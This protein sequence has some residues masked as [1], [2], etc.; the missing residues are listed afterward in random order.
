[1][2]PTSPTTTPSH[3]AGGA[4]TSRRLE[5]DDLGRF[6]DAA[7]A[8]STAHEQICA[9]R[10]PFVAATGEL[11]QDLGDPRLAAQHEG[12]VEQM[13]RTMDAL[14]TCFEQF[15]HLLTEVGRAYQRTDDAAARGTP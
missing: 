8:F 14:E 9:A 12:S 15:S 3:G 2:S 11:S 7:A 5:I 6:D 13:L 4:P 1:M 10:G